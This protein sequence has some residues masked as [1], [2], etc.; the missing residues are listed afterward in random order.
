MAM[1]VIKGTKT[2]SERFAGC[3][4]YLYYRSNDAGWKSPSGRNLPFSGTE[5]CQRPLT[6]N[7]QLRKENK[8]MFGLPHGVFQLV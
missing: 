5:F 4:G 3:I 7:I 8:I 6:L 1:P 2:E